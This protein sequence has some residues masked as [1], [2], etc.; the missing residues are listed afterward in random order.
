M[1]GALPQA[2]EGAQPPKPQW[3]HVSITRRGDQAMAS[4]ITVVMC[5][6]V[7]NQE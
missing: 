1:E 4:S 7:S 5:L 2:V 3:R 6:L